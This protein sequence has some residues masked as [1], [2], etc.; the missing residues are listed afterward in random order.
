M[1]GAKKQ[2]KAAA[3]V[4]SKTRQAMHGAYKEGLK[5]AREIENAASAESR[6]DQ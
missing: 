5:L 6:R 1:V 4:Q 3:A 2:K